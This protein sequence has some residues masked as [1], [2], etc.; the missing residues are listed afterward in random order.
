M[1]T[2]LQEAE[3]GH[4]GA[5]VPDAPKD[6]LRRAERTPHEGEGCRQ[7]QGG[8][9]EA[10]GADLGV[11]GECVQGCLSGGERTGVLCVFVM[12]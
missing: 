8:Q 4:V 11:E 5:A 3:V 10:Q 7:P 1:I 12:L 2:I 9:R 6:R